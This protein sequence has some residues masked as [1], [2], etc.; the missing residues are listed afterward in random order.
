M[1]TGAAIRLLACGAMLTLAVNWGAAQ[2][3]RANIPF[4]FVAGSASLAAGEYMVEGAGL[5]DQILQLC[6]VKS[7]GCIVMLASEVGSSRGA[8]QG[9]FVFHR[10]GGQYFLSEVWSPNDGLVKTLPESRRERQ[11]A[12]SGTESVV[13]IMAAGLRNGLR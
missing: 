5:S 9:K 2:T 1:K 4:N 12:K 8:I 13:A 6:G 11:L 10:Y 7:R 3:V